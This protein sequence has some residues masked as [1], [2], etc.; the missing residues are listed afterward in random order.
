MNW[1]RFDICGAYWLF[2]SRYHGGQNSHGYRKLSQL[3]R[4]KYNPGVGLQFGKFETENQKQIY[5]QL[6]V[7]ER[8]R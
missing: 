1:D 4:M 6:V 8:S 7:K 5:N 3:A 2:Y